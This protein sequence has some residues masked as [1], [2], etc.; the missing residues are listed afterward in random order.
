M[1]IAS[2]NG[3]FEEQLVIQNEVKKIRVTH[4]GSTFLPLAPA[5][6]LKTWKVPKEGFYAPIDVKFALTGHVSEKAG[7]MAV[8]RLVDLRDNS[9]A[10]ILYVSPQIN[11]AVG[12]R[13]EGSQL[14]FCLAVGEYPLQFEVTVSR[15]QFKETAKIYST[16]LEWRMLCSPTPL[17]RVKAVFAS[18]TTS[19]MM[20][21]PSY[22]LIP[23]AMTKSSKGP[24]GRK[25]KN[26]ANDGMATGNGVT[27]P[28][29]VGGSSTLP[30][31]S[32]HK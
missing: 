19:T 32:T 15:S 12:L 28:G 29:V 30:I 8:V 5:G 25:H 9:P 17:S 27:H 13:I 1:E 31:P 16:S 14:P 20:I 10:R 2:L 11:L 18:T 21:E 22:S 3:I 6:L 24:R 23:K 7:V 4:S 26:T